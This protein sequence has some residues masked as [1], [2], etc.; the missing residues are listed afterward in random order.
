MLLQVLQLRSSLLLLLLLVVLLLR[1]SLLLLLLLVLLLL[2][3]SL[4]LLLT[5]LALLLWCLSVRQGFPLL[6]EFSLRTP[7]T[8]LLFFFRGLV[9][10]RGFDRSSD[11]GIH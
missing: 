6:H 2:R 9:C 11:A 4:L 8:P 10:F 7:P 1:L 3:L 5:L